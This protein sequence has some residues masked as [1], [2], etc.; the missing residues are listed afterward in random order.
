MLLFLFM[1]QNYNHAYVKKLHAITQSIFVSSFLS[2][3][4]YAVQ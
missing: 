4:F 3:Y 2:Q 1:V